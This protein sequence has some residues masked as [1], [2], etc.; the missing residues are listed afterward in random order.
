MTAFQQSATLVLMPFVFANEIV[1]TLLKEKITGLA[2]VPTLWS[3]IA[4]PNSNLH[5]RLFPHL[6]YITNTEVHYRNPC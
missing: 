4:Q 1:Q 5:K 6:R 2:G 3:L